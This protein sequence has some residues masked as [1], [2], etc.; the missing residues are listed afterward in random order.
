MPKWLIHSFAVNSFNP[1]RGQAESSAG[2]RAANGRVSRMATASAVLSC[3]GLGVGHLLGLVLAIAAV[4]RMDDSKG[5]LY[6]YRLVLTGCIVGLVGLF[7]IP[8]G[9]PPLV[10]N[11]SDGSQWAFWLAALIC[12]IEFPIF[13][14][15]YG[16]QD[17]LAP[18]ACEYGYSFLG[19]HQQ[20]TA[21]D[22]ILAIVGSV[23][24]LGLVVLVILWH[25]SGNLGISAVSG[26][27]L[28][29]SLSLG[30]LWGRRGCRVLWAFVLVALAL[31]VALSLLRSV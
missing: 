17:R 9:L 27:V 30:A 15:L 19:P 12:Q 21:G 22:V 4:R 16:L 18:P 10:Q 14:L 11:S 23:L 25:L 13:M 8:F 28:L 6:G 5:S 31:G 24:G 7:W 29:V 2:T 20:R 3:I 26:G 1:Q